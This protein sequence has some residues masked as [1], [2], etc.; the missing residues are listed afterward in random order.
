MS[1]VEPQ[2]ERGHAGTALDAGALSLPGVLM[3]ALTHIAPTIGMIFAVQ[4]ITASAG[5]ASPF[6]LVLAGGVMMTVAVS[7]M[8]LARKLPSA[9]GY[10]HWIST[11]VGPR[12][13]YLIAWLFFIYE[14]FGAAINLS[15]LGGILESTFKSEYGFTLPWWVTA[16]AGGLILAFLTLNGVRLSVR[17]IVVLGAVE[18]ALCVALA[19]TGLFDPGPG[20]LT[21]APFNP[22]NA[23]N[24]N[25]LFLGIVFAIFTYAGFESVAPLAEESRD[26]RRILPRAVVLSLTIAIVFML[27]TSWGVLV[28]YGTDRVDA[29]VADG[30]P[31]FALAHRVWGGAWVLLIVAFVNSCLGVGL[32]VQNA[33]SRVL[34]GMARAGALP[35]WLAK[36]D[37]KRKTP[38]NAVLLQS[39]ITIGAALIGGA[40]FGPVEF[41]A[42]VAIIITLAAVIIYSAGNLGVFRLYRREHPDELSVFLHVICPVVS[43]IALL[44]VGYKTLDPLPTGTNRW[45][46]IVLI[47]W[48]AIGVV[49]MLASG[50]N[51]NSWL[52]RAGSAAAEEG[53]LEGEL[54]HSASAEV[55]S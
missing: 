29:L 54:F 45:A 17:T 41:L 10:F 48:A 51:R 31:V 19:L 13:G 2:H 40:A 28:G 49:V 20:G 38:I 12:A 52:A 33:S 21:L 23:T 44:Y 35:Q 3:Q 16:L 9:G 55:R 43:T 18:I 4:A 36:V 24:F 50:R 27:I 14:P 1:K 15:F 5:L 34:F 53:E 32:A 11:S 25:G 46:P 26:P 47:A 22:G 39:A 30:S 6:A 37:P 7:V 42:F 8:Q